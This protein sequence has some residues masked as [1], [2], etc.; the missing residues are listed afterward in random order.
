LRR[1]KVRTNSKGALIALVETKRRKWIKERG[2]HESVPRESYCLRE[3][4]E[5]IG[6][7]Q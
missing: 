3:E 6:G 1:M 2:E 5:R 7:E 4:E